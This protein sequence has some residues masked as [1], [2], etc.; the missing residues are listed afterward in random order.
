MLYQYATWALSLVDIT[1]GVCV[2]V[3]CQSHRLLKDTVV[4]SSKC[5]TFAL[6]ANPLATQQPFYSICS[7]I[8]LPTV[9][10][11]SLHRMNTWQCYE[12]QMQ[13]HTSSE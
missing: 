2:G 11:N 3:C 7:F 13:I 1:V 12:I 9:R 4:E 5:K 10:F 8:F 6:F